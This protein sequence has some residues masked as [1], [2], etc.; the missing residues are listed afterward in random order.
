MS[1]VQHLPELLQRPVVRMDIFVIGNVIAVIRI[2]RRKDGAEPDPVHPQGFDIVKFFIDS[3]QISDPVS[4]P[5]AE[6]PDPDLVKRHFPE[7]E[8]LFLHH[9][10]RFSPGCQPAIHLYCFFLSV[11]LRRAL[12]L[13]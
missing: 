4:V 13:F 8:L 7:I 3:V 5:V 9:L 1:P 11:L 6:A 2:G 12:C 10:V